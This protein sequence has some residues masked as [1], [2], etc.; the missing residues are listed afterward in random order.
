MPSSGRTKTCFFVFWIGATVV[1]AD[2]APAFESDF[3]GTVL[4]GLFAGDD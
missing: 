1:A 4:P 2:F 3:E